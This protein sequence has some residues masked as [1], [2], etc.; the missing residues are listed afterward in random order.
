MRLY[1]AKIP[2][3]AQEVTKALMST[4]DIEAETPKEVEADIASVLTQYLAVERD[5]NQKAKEL[6]ERTGRGMDEFNRVRTQIAE[7]K[8]IR[9]GDEALDYVLDQIVEMLHH[10]QNVDEI[11]AEDVVMRRKAGQILKRHLTADD[12][13]DADVRAQLKHVKEGT[14]TWDIEYQRVLE[15]IKRAKGL[16]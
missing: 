8:G 13:L 12:A 15:G 11:F 3:V 16:S 5:V 1:A 7:S 10:S 6:L 14:R 2:L 4:Q 9:V